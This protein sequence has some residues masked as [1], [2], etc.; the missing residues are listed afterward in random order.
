MAKKRKSQDVID[1]GVRQEEIGF[2]D[3]LRRKKP[4]QTAKPRSGVEDENVPAAAHF[5][6]GRIAAVAR[7]VLAGTRYRSAHAPE[8]DEE[9]AIHAPNPLRTDDGAW[10]SPAGVPSG[11]G[12]RRTVEGK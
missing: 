3:A 6:A 7:G 11:C 9:I 4:S 5:D 8:T 12:D 10:V 2:G 1:M